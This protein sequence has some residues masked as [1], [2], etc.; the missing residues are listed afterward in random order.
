MLNK[1]SSVDLARLSCHL[2]H[3]PRGPTA[4]ISP[5][6]GPRTLAIPD[7]SRPKAPPTLVHYSDESPYG[8][9][10]TS[11]QHYYDEQMR[12][13][14]DN[15]ARYGS[16]SHGPATDSQRNT[17][18][19]YE[20]HMHA[21]PQYEGNTQAPCRSGIQLPIHPGPPNRN[22]CSSNSSN[23]YSDRRTSLAS[24]STATTY[25]GPTDRPGRSNGNSPETRILPPLGASESRNGTREQTRVSSHGRP[26][27]DFAE[28]ERRVD[29]GPADSRRNSMLLQ[30]PYYEYEHEPRYEQA[31][32][33]REYSREARAIRQPVS[34]QPAGRQPASHPSV[35]KPNGTRERVEPPPQP[36]N[37]AQLDAD[38]KKRRGNLPKEVTEMLRQWF[39]DHIAHPYPT[40]EEKQ[41]LMH[42]TGLNMSQVGET[43]M[44]PGDRC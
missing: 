16:R 5:T 15:Q 38:G 27:Y 40:E 34:R 22:S 17:S 1:R 36:V 28:P 10:S 42:L 24:T 12:P 4:L 8:D 21:A 23:D 43:M 44:F 6:Y 35:N 13:Y 31:R 18:P 32:E 25:S 30:Q 3:N 33:S 9:F 26:G 11:P 14:Y 39:A 37:F 41:R 19:H 29:H 20:G 7:S 2:H